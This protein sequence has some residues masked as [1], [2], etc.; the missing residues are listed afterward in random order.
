MCSAGQQRHQYRIVNSRH[1]RISPTSLYSQQYEKG[2]CAHPPPRV[3]KKR[4][5]ARARAR[6]R[7]DAILASF[8]AQQHI[9]VAGAWFGLVHVTAQSIF[10]PAGGGLAA[11]AAWHHAGPVWFVPGV[12]PPLPGAGGEFPQKHCRWSSTAAYLN[13]LPSPR[14]KGKQEGRRKK[15]KER[16]K[17]HCQLRSSGMVAACT[18]PC[19]RAPFLVAG[20]KV[21]V[22]S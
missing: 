12:Q 16:K 21:K 7:K 15:K 18:A 22:V 1:A 9:R 5:Q 4:E 17:P 2:R 13:G 8:P 3:C 14:V 6:T 10:F 11:V 19:A 20:S